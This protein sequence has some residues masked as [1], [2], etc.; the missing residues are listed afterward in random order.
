MDNQYYE[1]DTLAYQL[2]YSS[3]DSDYYNSPLRRSQKLPH[4]LNGYFF[5]PW[6]QQMCRAGTRTSLA[7]HMPWVNVTILY[8]RRVSF[9]R[10]VLSPETFEW[11]DIVATE[12][13]MCLVH[14][15]HR[16]L[17]PSTVF[18]ALVSVTSRRAPVHA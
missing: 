4:D 1:E 18:N 5:L 2:Q 11:S 17:I 15:H 7:M 6:T 9:G 8:K 13:L 10:V 12:V 16:S 3:P 14:P